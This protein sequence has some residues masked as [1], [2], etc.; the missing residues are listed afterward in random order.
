MYPIPLVVFVIIY[1]YGDG[2]VVQWLLM[3]ALLLVLVYYLFG[4]LMYVPVMD[5]ELL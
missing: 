2:G 5:G 4:E 3:S 1:L